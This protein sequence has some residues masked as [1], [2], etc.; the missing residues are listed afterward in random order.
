MLAVVEAVNGVL[1]FFE[2]NEGDVSAGLG[3]EALGQSLGNEAIG[4]F[5]GKPRQG[6]DPF[7]QAR[8]SAGGPHT[9]AWQREVP[10]SSFGVSNRL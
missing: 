6:E 2:G 3:V 4:K 8:E 1:P 5:L 10:G 9:R 7:G